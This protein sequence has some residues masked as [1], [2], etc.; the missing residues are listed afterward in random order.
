MKILSS[1]SLEEL[2]NI[3][4]VDEKFV[5][6]PL[7]ELVSRYSLL[8]VETEI[9][10]PKNFS[11]LDPLN[12]SWNGNMDKENAVLMQKFFPRLSRA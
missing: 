3:V 11:L 6:E 5:L 2:R 9:E 7:E 4:R 10:S 1:N 12:D 8:L